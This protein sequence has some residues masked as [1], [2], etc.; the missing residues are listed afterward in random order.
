MVEALVGVLA[1]R[2][3]TI[4]EGLVAVALVVEVLGKANVA[5]EGR[6]MMEEVWGE[7]RT[8]AAV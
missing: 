8:V 5:E 3:M 7:E 1:E 4:E 6:V 2:G